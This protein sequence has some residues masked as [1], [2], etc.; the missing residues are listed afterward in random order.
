MQHYMIAQIFLIIINIKKMDH[1]DSFEG[2]LFYKIYML[3]KGNQ[4]NPD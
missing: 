1:I 2:K 3:C 4:I